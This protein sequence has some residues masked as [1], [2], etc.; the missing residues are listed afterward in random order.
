[1]SLLNPSVPIV[2]I[3]E[4]L[5]TASVAR[6]ACVCRD[7]R[8]ACAEQS[9]WLDLSFPHG[10]NNAEVVRRLCARAGAALRRVDLIHADSGMDIDSIVEDMSP[11]ESL[12]R[13]E[14]AR[15]HHVEKL[16]HRLTAAHLRVPCVALACSALS[17]CTL[18]HTLLID[19]LLSD[20][21]HMP[22]L[23]NAIDSR[24]VSKN[25]LHLVAGAS[26]ARLIEAAYFNKDFWKLLVR[27]TKVQLVGYGL[28]DGNM[29]A[30]FM[31]FCKNIKD[32]GHFFSV[33]DTQPNRYVLLT[34]KR[35]CASTSN[36][37]RST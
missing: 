35:R 29:F 37:I 26:S 13:V 25:D 18:Y 1:M 31:N 24:A 32:S 16:R 20:Q 22:A 23:M 34:S 3:L 12:L 14:Y 28:N 4:L 19:D 10:F 2:R 6:A 9:L 21:S 33:S 15:W 30:M 8:K 27:F 36:Y 5:D 17:Q 11:G 7:L